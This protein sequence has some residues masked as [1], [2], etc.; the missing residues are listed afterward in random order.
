MG[1]LKRDQRR[2]ALPARRP[3]A[4]RAEGRGFFGAGRSGLERMEKTKIDGKKE[5]KTGQEQAGKH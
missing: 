2:P 1:C 5:E 3:V 4:V